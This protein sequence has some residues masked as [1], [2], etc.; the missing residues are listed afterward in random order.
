MHGWIRRTLGLKKK[1][2]ITLCRRLNIISTNDPHI[3]GNFPP[4][5]SNL[6]LPHGFRKRRDSPKCM[7]YAPL[8][9]FLPN[10]PNASACG[11]C[12]CRLAR[13][14]RGAGETPCGGGSDERRDRSTAASRPWQSL[15]RCD[16]RALRTFVGFVIGVASCRGW[17]LLCARMQPAVCFVCVVGVWRGASHDATLFAI[18]H[19]I[20]ISVL[21][22]FVVNVLFSFES[23]NQ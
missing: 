13:D 3:V 12:A 21:V 11:S 15:F 5:E 10:K 14:R 8:C 23:I 4:C 22:L 7:F 18:P 1:Q 9:F 20:F 2:E 17:R 16:F 6:R 19:L